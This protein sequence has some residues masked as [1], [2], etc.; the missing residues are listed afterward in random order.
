MGCRWKRWA[1]RGGWGWCAR[2][3]R[4]GIFALRGAPARVAARLGISRAALY[5]DL[6][7]IKEDV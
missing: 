7:T 2:C 6:A 3:T 1:S 5:N 4:R